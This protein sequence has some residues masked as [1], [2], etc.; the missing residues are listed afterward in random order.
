MTTMIDQIGG[1]E[2]L[3]EL[4]EHFY[5]LVETA[6]EAQRLLDLHMDGHGLAH[7]REEQFNFMSGFMGGRQYYLE[8]HRH[9][10]VREIHAHV[11]IFPQDAGLWLSVMDRTLQDLGH[12][13]PKV[14]RLRT[15]LR[16]VAL[17]LVNDGVV[18]GA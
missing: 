4:V 14:E 16:K 9:M 8:K 13:G 10:N 11:P 5:D 12:V 1:E 17:M 6:P 18:Q 15:T 2:G 3:R 7:T